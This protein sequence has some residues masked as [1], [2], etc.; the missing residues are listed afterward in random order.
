MAKIVRIGRSASNDICI[1]DSMVSSS[2][3]ILTVNSDGS[4][5]VEDCGSTNGTFVNG[6]RITSK[7][8]LNPGDNLSFAS[9]SYN[10]QSLVKS[11]TKM[12]SLKQAT[13]MV[14]QRPQTERMQSVQHRGTERISSSMPIP[15][16]DNNENEKMPG[17]GDEQKVIG[18]DPSSDI[19]LNTSEVSSRHALLCRTHDGFVFII[20]CDSTNGTFVN[21]KRVHKKYLKSGD[22]VLLSNKYMLDWEFY[23]PNPKS[24][25]SV[26]FAFKKIGLA[27]I[28]L[29]GGAL[30]SG[31]GYY[32]WKEYFR[33]PKPM[34][35]QEIYSTY[36]H[37]V[38]MIYYRYTYA[39]KCDG[40]SLSSYLD[41]DSFDYIYLD[42][43]GKLNTGIATGF[44]TGFF[45]S[46]DGKIMTNRH[47]V[48]PGNEKSTAQ[49]EK[50]VKAAIS[51]AFKAAASEATANKA[52][53]RLWY[54]AENVTATFKLI[55]LGVF[56]ND[57]YVDSEDDMLPCSIYR[58]S[59]DEELDVAII[60]TNNKRTPVEVDKIVDMKK[61]LNSEH[62]SLGS[63][64]Y[65]IGFPY[66]T[67]IGTTREGLEANNQSGE[68]TQERGIYTY[69]HNI[70]I[71]SGASG[72][73]V[74]DTYGDFAGIIVSGFLGISQGYN[75][76]IQP[77]KAAAFYN[78]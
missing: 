49:C 59:Q 65:T 46:N 13:Q 9:H 67:I 47:V 64:I 26:A 11:L 77:Q 25:S 3:A 72:S 76:A 6:R 75:H 35:P 66:A 28:I 78:Q 16:W 4:V 52:K 29:L 70:T 57:T 58:I 42:N 44:G 22:H 15:G 38:V 32:V 24:H 7:C 30:L 54:I 51:E 17:F 12:G 20:D 8:S 40:E 34:L 45:I 14:S 18:R 23:Y 62:L 41:D 68:V 2:H 10:W 39:I 1:S 31:A 55:K 73:P 69:G 5:V 19:R 60:Q 50:E 27:I 63:K 61:E 21:G 53:Y 74:F 33:G 37:S 43:N 56:L 36:K 71:H 48:T